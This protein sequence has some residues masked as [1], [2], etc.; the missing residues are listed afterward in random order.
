MNRKSIRGESIY[1]VYIRNFSKNGDID[2]LISKLREIKELGITIIWILPHY[3]IGEVNRKGNLGSPYS[4]KDYTDINPDIGNLNSFKKLIKEVHKLK[5]KLII[6]IVFNHTS[7]DSILLNEHPDWFLTNRGEIIGKVQNWSDVVDL[8]FTNTSLWDYL[9]DVLIFWTKLGVD[10]FRC[11]VAS[12]VPIEFWIKAREKVEEIRKGLLWLGESVDKEFIS[13]IRHKGYN[14][15]SDSELYRAFDILYD[16]DIQCFTEGYMEG[17][18][19]FDTLIHELRNQEV[20]FPEDYLKLRFLENHDSKKR[21]AD[22]IKD[23]YKLK[24]WKSFSMFQKGVPL[25][26][27]GEELRLKKQPNL[28]NKDE[29]QWDKGN[30]NY[31]EFI[32]RLLEINKLEIVKKGIY[33]INPI[34]KDCLH[35]RYRF[36]GKTLHGI[37]NLGNRNREIPFESLEGTY[38]NLVNNS[39]FTISNSGLKLIGAPFIF[40]SIP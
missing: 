37:F 14:C 2:S 15:H 6:D 40:K 33:T 16:Y 9:I 11:D 27:N 31:R 19:N 7:L 17:R 8:D 1:S 23:E 21:I 29:T 35:L 3:P 22:T 24:N 34:I 10:G 25:I 28:F 38:I 26:Y 32:K 12:V 20:V 39:K 36:K 5:L 30:Y 18:I 13:F 4:I